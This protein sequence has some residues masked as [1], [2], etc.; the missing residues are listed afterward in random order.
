MCRLRPQSV[1]TGMTDRQ[2]DATPQSPQPS[3][4][5]SLMKT[6]CGRSAISPFLR[7]R[8]SSAAQ[9]WS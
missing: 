9:V 8:R 4:T 6:R 3:H 7:R 5:I 2:F 1:S